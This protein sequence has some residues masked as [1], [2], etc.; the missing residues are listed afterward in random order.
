MNNKKAGPVLQVP[1]Q[2]K[3]LTQELIVFKVTIVNIECKIWL[4][5][6]RN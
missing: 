6:N 4:W 5:F 2:T 3:T 1:A